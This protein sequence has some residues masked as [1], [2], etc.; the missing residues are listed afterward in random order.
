MEIHGRYTDAD[1]DVDR[2]GL[3]CGI[4]VLL[5]NVYNYM[6]MYNYI[7]MYVFIAHPDIP[8][9]TRDDIYYMYMYMHYSLQQLH[10]YVGVC[11]FVSFGPGVRVIVCDGIGDY[12]Q[13][14]ISHS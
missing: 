9:H 1:A 11:R 7:E 4:H 14:F 10:V 12:R 2:T 5:K 13:K 6:Y 8:S 3:S